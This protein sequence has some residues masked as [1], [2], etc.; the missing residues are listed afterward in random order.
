[1]FKH[2][3][4]YQLNNCLN[5]YWLISKMKLQR[6]FSKFIFCLKS[7]CDMRECT[8]ITSMIDKMRGDRLFDI[9]H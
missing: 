2:P 5:D 4:Q 1:M 3:K 9:Y 8:D 6:S 7:K